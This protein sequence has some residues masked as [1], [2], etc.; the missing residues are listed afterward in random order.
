MRRPIPIGAEGTDRRRAP[1]AF[2]AIGLL[3]LLLLSVATDPATGHAF[4]TTTVDP[5]LWT[6]DP[7]DLEIPSGRS[8]HFAVTVGEDVTGIPWWFTVL[9]HCEAHRLRLTI[10]SAQEELMF[11]QVLAFPVYQMRGGV[12]VDPGQGPTYD[13]TITNYG[14]RTVVVEYR[15]ALTY[16]TSAGPPPDDRSA[17]TRLDSLGLPLATVGGSLLAGAAA[18]AWWPRHERGAPE[19]RRRPQRKRGGRRR[20][21]GPRE[22]GALVL[23]L[24]LVFLAAPVSIPVPRTDGLTAGRAAPPPSANLTTVAI[25]SPVDEGSVHGTVEVSGTS[26]VNQTLAAALQMDM[27]IT[28][29]YV[30][31]DFGPLRPAQGTLSWSYTWNT[32]WEDNGRTWLGAVAEDESGNLTYDWIVVDVENGMHPV[33]TASAIPIRGF[34][35]LDVA[36]SGSATDADDAVAGYVW[37][38]G[39]GNTSDLRSPTHTY[40]APGIYTARFTAID[41]RG[42]RGNATVTI[43]VLDPS[44]RPS[45]TARAIVS[46]GPDSLQVRLLGSAWDDGTITTLHWDFGDGT[47]GTGGN[48][49]HT[50]ARPGP[51]AVTFTVTDDDGFTSTSRFGIN[52]PA[53]I[54]PPRLFPNQNADPMRYPLTPRPE[55]FTGLPV[56]RRLT[57]ILP[58]LRAG[59]VIVWRYLTCGCS[60]STFQFWLQGPAGERILP[61]AF[62][63]TA[64]MLNATNYYTVR[65]HGVYSLVWENDGPEE[66]ELAYTAGVIFAHQGPGGVVDQPVPAPLPFRFLLGTGLL[67]AGSLALTAAARRRRR[68]RGNRSGGQPT[69]SRRSAAGE[70]E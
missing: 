50:Y 45:C 61:V 53:P 19:K 14:G 29:I 8:V 63:T 58:A 23:L 62:N 60:E 22:P 67:V 24:L 20:P 70:E 31:V 18:A 44:R 43:T 57:T 21:L 15:T 54:A 17:L 2:A 28:A 33:A 6:V 7:V 39:D 68:R 13:F 64:L 42:T 37:E 32:S 51:Y 47:T 65:A 9:C 34:A 69:G 49:T 12:M 30:T 11:D 55:V 3:I 4:S 1:S 27:N 10:E 5:V 66:L 56:D 48:L 35:P 16:P 36:F 46:T 59:D 25:I 26:M 38:F 40:A 41:A 52:V